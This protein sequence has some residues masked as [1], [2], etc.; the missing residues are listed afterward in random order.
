MTI[1][2]DLIMFKQK[3]VKN[4]LSNKSKLQKNSILKLNI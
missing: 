1:L 4:I 2:H 3:F